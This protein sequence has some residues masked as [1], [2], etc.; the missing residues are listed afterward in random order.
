LDAHLEAVRFCNTQLAGMTAESIAAELES[1]GLRPL[2][3]DTRVRCE[4][5]Y[6]HVYEWGLARGDAEPTLVE[7][8]RY[9]AELPAEQRTCSGQL[10]RDATCRQ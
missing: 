5:L 6:T 10:A 8:A 3:D 2:G 7:Y 9:R 4:Q 1:V